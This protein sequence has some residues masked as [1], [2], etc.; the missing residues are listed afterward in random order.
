MVER[1]GWGGLGGSTVIRSDE[2]FA[3]GLLGWPNSSHGIVSFRVIRIRF[4]PK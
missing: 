4:S 1:R 2:A 3:E